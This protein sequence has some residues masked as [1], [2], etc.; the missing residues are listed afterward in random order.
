MKFT[1]TEALNIVEEAFDKKELNVAKDVLSKLSL[2]YPDDK[3]VKYLKFKY[4]ITQFCSCRS[5]K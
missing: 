4:N 1:V 2:I 5:S 3:N